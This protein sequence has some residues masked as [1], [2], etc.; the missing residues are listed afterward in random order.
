[1]RSG[2]AAA[3]L[4][5]SV[6]VVY[7]TFVASVVRRSPDLARACLAALLCGAASVFVLNTEASTVHERRGRSPVRRRYLGGGERI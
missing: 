4:A 6:V 5:V 2:F 1:M 7:V 3:C